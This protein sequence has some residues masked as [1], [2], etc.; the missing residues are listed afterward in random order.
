MELVS[1]GLFMGFSA[2]LKQ[3]VKSEKEVFLQKL[4]KEVI[5]SEELLRLK[6]ILEGEAK[7]ASGRRLVVVGGV[8]GLIEAY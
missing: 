3:E 6:E 7:K 8:L 4:E 2:E 5:T 1:L